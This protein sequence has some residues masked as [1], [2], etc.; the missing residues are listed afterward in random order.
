MKY[1]IAAAM[2]AMLAAC[3]AGGGS[4]QTPA[5][6]GSTCVVAPAALVL[7][8]D[9][10]SINNSGSDTATLTVTALDANRNALS[11]ATVTIVPDSGTVATGGS[12]TTDTNGHLVG[13]IDIGGDKTDR[14]ITVE[15]KSGSIT[16]TATVMVTGA[17]FSGAANPGVLSPGAAGVITYTLTDVNGNAMANF[18]IEVDGP[19]TVNDVTDVNGHYTYNYTAP[20]T[21]G[22]LN[23]TAKAGGETTT[24]AITITSGTVPAAVGTVQSATLSANPSVI[25][26]NSAGDTSNQVEVRALFLGANNAPIKNIRVR[27]DL[28][29]DTN[30]I[31]GTLSSGNN[32]VYSD[33]NG[34]ARTQ[35]IPGTRSSGTNKLTIRGCWSNTDFTAVTSGAACPNGQEVTASVT[36]TDAGTSL[37]A[38]TDLKLTEDDTRSVYTMPFSVQVV[39]GAG[40]PRSGIKV[41]FSSKLTRFYK[42]SFDGS[43]GAWVYGI[44]AT[45]ENEDINGNLKLDKSNDVT[46]NEDA[47]LNNRLDPVQAFA[48]LLPTSTGSDTTDVY[49]KAY[50]TLEWGQSAAF[51]NAYELDFS[52]TVD[53]TEGHFSYTGDHLPVP[54]DA[55]SNGKA[56]PPFVRS[57][58]GVNPSPTTPVKDPG[59]GSVVPLCT[60]AS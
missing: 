55:L 36:I 1:V 13:T 33:D 46:T 27:F 28:D 10:S 60:D 22:T 17:K 42:G 2:A 21:V 15:V 59:T 45:C 51:W 7:S 54:A 49:G 18:P 58:Y 19:T 44:A 11:G 14:T 39:D 5:C 47:N 37:S 52:A 3:S 12:T 6:S 43:S 25:S 35:Y 56:E 4:S 57:P 24:S 50:F 34:Y 9:K 32:Y 40:H 8:L 20:S 53:G 31:G 23:V 41:A 38:F 26:V 16:Q 30:N 48:T 29:G